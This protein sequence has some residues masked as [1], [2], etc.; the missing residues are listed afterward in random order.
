MVNKAMLTKR[1]DLYIMYK[2]INTWYKEERY[3][4]YSVEGGSSVTGRMP[5]YG[6]FE[7]L[8]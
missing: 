2:C 6:H 8:P 1:S 3:Y 4:N 5:L 7:M